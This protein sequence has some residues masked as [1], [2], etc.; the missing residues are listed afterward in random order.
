MVLLRVD[1]KG[2]K[3][4]RKVEKMELKVKRKVEQK[5]A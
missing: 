3:V 4:K 2:L 1:K 5:V